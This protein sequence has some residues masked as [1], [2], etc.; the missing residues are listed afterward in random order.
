MNL[1]ISKY[2][3]INTDKS[4]IIK[5]AGQ[6]F[7]LKIIGLVLSYAFNIL[8]ARMYG[9]G[10]MGV[11]A[12]SITVLNIF[13]LLGLMGTKISTIRFVAQNFSKNK[14]GA[15][16]PIYKKILAIVF[17]A[18]FSA[19]IVFALSATFIAERIFNKPILKPAWIKIF[20]SH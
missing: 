3:N 10:A 8:L 19:M 11:Y 13:T 2:L 1:V 20:L 14:L 18:S 5:G 4:E 7:I 12:L 9:P 17:P 6:T 15:I 16:F